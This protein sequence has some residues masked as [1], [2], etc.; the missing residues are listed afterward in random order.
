MI[1]H[2]YNPAFSPSQ[3]ALLAQLNYDES[4]VAPYELPSPLICQ[5]G[6][7][8]DSAE[9]WENKR[10]PE[11][12]ALFEEQVYGRMLPKIRIQA[13]LVEECQEALSGK[14]TRRQVTISFPDHAGPSLHLALYFPNKSDKPTP[15]FLGL[16]FHGNHAAFDDPAIRLSSAWM[17][18]NEPGVINNHST[19]ASRATGISRWP[20]D[21]IIDR[22]Y[23]LATLYYGDIEPDH[24]RGF[25]QSVRSMF[26]SSSE[27]RKGDDAGAITAWAWGLSRVM[28]YL[29]TVSEIDADRVCLTGH[30]RLG[31][32]SLWAGAND[33]RFALVIS[34]NSGCGGAALSRRNFGETLYALSNVQPHWFCENCRTQSE[35]IG[36]LSV[37]QHM[38][39][40]L[41]APR[42]IFVSSAEEDHPADPQGEYS[43]C[44]NANDVYRIL[45]T[46]G[47]ISQSFPELDHP[48]MST[49]GYV[50][51][52]GHH[53]IT[54]ADWEHHLHFADLHLRSV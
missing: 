34:N 17:R 4:R 21:K 33:R 40:S 19:P 2:V 36:S 16:N 8:V 1:S 54:P 28:D 18:P 53:D 43:S 48:I 29:E 38:L 12:L 31:K 5:D 44:R 49:I 6:T 13:D 11:I 45:G 20:L 35:N 7:I 32:T 51:R 15:C 3:N 14:A 37:D 9:L 10:R 27:H 25:P 22:G 52:P 30:S 23:A 39:I 24:E 42:P 50:I 47:M 26:L 46:K 41:I